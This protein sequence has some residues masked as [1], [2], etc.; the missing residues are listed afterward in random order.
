[1]KRRFFRNLRFQKLSLKTFII[2]VFSI[3][4]VLLPAKAVFASTTNG[5]L[6]GYAWSDAI[7]WVN[8]G[9][10]NGGASITDSVVT[11]Y[12]W[13]ENM[14]RLNL[15]PTNSGVTNDSNG[16][17]AGKAWLEGTGWFN[18]SGVTVNSS[19]A[20]SGTATGDNS[21]DINFG[22]TNCAVTTDWR[23]ANSRSSSGGGGGGSVSGVSSG[24]VSGTYNGPFS[25]SIN[26]NQQYTNN[27]AVTFVLEGGS[28]VEKMMLSNLADFSNREKEV[29]QKTK[30]WSLNQGDGVKTVYAK[31]YNINGS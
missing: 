11:G 31:F 7:G 6:S 16:T 5:T 29:F 21:V 20:F 13:N 2:L 3:V 14:G 1:M 28:D 25:I 4:F 8:F 18:F 10:T 12:A 9:T 30:A 15:N 19:G 17:L 27:L 23:P 24:G 26:N 22:C